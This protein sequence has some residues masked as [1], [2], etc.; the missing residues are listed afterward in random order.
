MQHGAL[1][2]ASLLQFPGCRSWRG[3]DFRTALLV[4]LPTGNSS[5]GAGSGRHEGSAAGA[6][7]R[8]ARGHRA[9][10]ARDGG[11][12]RCTHRHPR[13]P[14]AGAAALAARLH[15][16]PGRGAARDRAHAHLLPHRH[17]RCFPDRHLCRSSSDAWTSGPRREAHLHTLYEYHARWRVSKGGH[18]AWV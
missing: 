1:V 9:A 5:G 7:V 10:R 2:D 8:R 14:V 18:R 13:R 17:H 4:S 15:A 6:A 16:E 12:S 3:L 11:R